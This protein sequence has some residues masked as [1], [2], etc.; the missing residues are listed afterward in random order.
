MSRFVV[1]YRAFLLVGNYLVAALQTAYYSVYRREKILF[2][3]EF[4]IMAGGYQ[5]RFIAYVGNIGARETGGL[6]CQKLAVERGAFARLNGGEN[7]VRRLGDRAPT[8]FGVLRS[9]ER[10]GQRRAVFANGGAIAKKIAGRRVDVKRPS[11]AFERIEN[12]RIIFECRVELFERGFVVGRRGFGGLLPQRRE[13]GFEQFFRKRGQIGLKRQNA[14][15]LVAKPSGWVGRRK[16]GFFSRFANEEPTVFFE[17]AEARIVAEKRSFRRRFDLFFQVG[18][19]DKFKFFDVRDR[20]KRERNDF[21]TVR[22][23]DDAERLFAVD[24]LNV[25]VNRPRG[26][27]RFGKFQLFSDAFRRSPNRVVSGARDDGDRSPIFIDV[28][29]RRRRRSSAAPTRR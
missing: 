19:A 8:G 24:A 28:R 21:G 26:L 6:F 27:D 15:F 9:G 20:Q 1:G 14:R 16:D 12:R 10:F 22:R 11:G 5:C 23:D 2:R 25:A 4:L 3:D 18:S 13:P 29:F 17:Q 7:G